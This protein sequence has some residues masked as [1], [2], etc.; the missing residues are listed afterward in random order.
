MLFRHKHFAK[1]RNQEALS[2]KS[3]YF[4]Q[5]NSSLYFAILFRGQTT[6]RETFKKNPWTSTKQLE[7]LTRH[8]VKE[9]ECV[10]R[11]IF[12]YTDT[13]NE[14]VRHYVTPQTLSIDANLVNATDLQ[15]NE[16][17]K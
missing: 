2:G 5:T 14:Q 7:Y 3:S 8:L 15:N 1:F 9:R 10:K 6:G 13:K 12:T 16:T 4:R 11:E 17:E